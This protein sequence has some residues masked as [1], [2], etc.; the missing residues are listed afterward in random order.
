[1]WSR[2]CVDVDDRGNVR[3]CSVEVHDLDG[4][5]TIWTTSVGPFDDEHAALQT[6]LDYLRSHI[7]TQTTLF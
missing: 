3:G 5:T 2:L 1:M 4:P 7:G 6:A